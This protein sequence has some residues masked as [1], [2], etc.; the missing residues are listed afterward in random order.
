[1]AVRC[2]IEPSSDFEAPCQVQRGK[3]LS[4]VVAH[5]KEHVRVHM[6]NR[7]DHLSCLIVPTRA[8]T[9]LHRLL[10]GC[11]LLQRF[12]STSTLGKAMNAHAKKPSTVLL[13]SVPPDLREEVS[14]RALDKSHV[15]Q[16]PLDATFS[17]RVFSRDLQCLFDSGASASFIGWQMAIKLGL[18]LR[19]S[20][21]KGVSTAAGR[22]VPIRGEAKCMV[23]FEGSH[24]EAIVHVLPSFLEGIHVI[25]GQDFMRKHSVSLGYDQHGATCTL[26]NPE[27]RTITMSRAPREASGAKISRNTPCHEVPE[28]P[29][30]GLLSATVAARVLKNPKYR[31]RAFIA[32]VKP[33]VNFVKEAR[34][35]AIPNSSSEPPTAVPHERELPSLDHITEDVRT[36]LHQLIDS[37]SDI[38]SES[39]QAGGAKVDIPEHAIELLPGSK[40]PFRKNYRL[41]PLEVEELRKQVTEFLAKGIITAANSPF[42]A[43]VL[44]VPKPN[45]T[46]LRFCLDYRALNELTVKTRY[47]LP[48][49]DDLLDA[50]RGATCFSAIDLASGYYQIPIAEADVP[51]TAFCT[52]WGQY[53]WRVLPMGL[54][55]AP[56]SFMRVMNKVFE[57]FI[58]DFVLVYLD[59]ILIMSRSPEEHL[60]H[61]RRVFQRL[62]DVSMQ[63]KL[64]KCKFMQEQIKYLGHILSKDGIRVD[65]A[66]VQ[67]LLDWEFPETALGMQQFLG[68]ANYF[69]KFVADYSR[70]AAPLYHLTKKG[71][72]FLRGEEVEHAFKAIKQQL[73]SPPVLAYPNPEL[74]YELIS[75]AS[76]TGCGAVLVQE[77]RPI[78]YFSSRFSSAER[79][80]TTGEQEMLGIIKAL[81]EWRCYLE[82]CKELTLVTDHNPLT[83]FSKQPTLSRRQA[84]WSEFL[85]RF[86]FQVKYRPGCSNP[87]DSLSRLHG[88]VLAVTLCE[89]DSDLLRRLKEATEHDIAFKD[90]RVCNKYTNEAGLWTFQGRIVVPESMRVAIMQ[91][92]HANPFSGHFGWARTLDLIARQFWWPSIR[93]DVQ[94]FVY[95]CASCQMNKATNTKPHGLLQ[96]LSIPDSRWHTVTM[97]FIM[98]LP[99]T[100][101]GN[102]AIMVLV[103]KLTK[104]VRLVPIQKESSAEQVARLFLVHWFQ[105]CGV[106]K[107]VIS[108]RDPRFTSQFLQ[109]ASHEASVFDGV[110]SSDRWADGTCQ[111]CNR[112]GTAAFCGW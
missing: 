38:F 103:D 51:K 90:E 7:P 72:L 35:G 89:C 96:P 104:Y 102:N 112:G 95:T 78:A 33:L 70:L 65:P 30:P 52:P 10:S 34:A 62:R 108:D 107:V 69:R 48:R 21:L 82:G 29:L 42:G 9:G 77:G 61:L 91:E 16:V 68:L 100:P 15:D 40:P 27:G 36:E 59:D 28:P 50:A 67:T 4:I 14:C 94:Q 58:G 41:S 43:P 105:F 60:V 97:D 83:F 64:S 26:H 63:V 17:G 109:E 8:V 88:T 53:E 18:T 79:N 13:F 25:L 76:L 80:Y 73:M 5:S 55:N 110:P 20:S 101:L 45:G 2:N 85:S 66:K 92:H 47:P 22:S 74:P 81:K 46:G 23:N 75:D 1:M 6:G 12:E 32:V 3:Q 24:F 84:R 87:A 31:S 93:A 99:R 71:A 37:F 106:P 98:D 86:D 111:S 49:I 54:T 56:S 39:P 57:Q 11:T 19:P 44:F